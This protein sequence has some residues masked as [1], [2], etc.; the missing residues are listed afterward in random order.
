MGLY[1]DNQPV[2]VD[3]KNSATLTYKNI[4]RHAGKNMATIFCW[5]LLFVWT[6]TENLAKDPRLAQWFKSYR[7]RRIHPPRSILRSLPNQT[8]NKL[9]MYHRQAMAEFTA[10]ILRCLV[11]I[12]GKELR[13]L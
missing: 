3:F 8:P 4:L 11:K 5:V 7:Q 9:E 6:S 2:P 13:L 10:S 1:Y 12:R